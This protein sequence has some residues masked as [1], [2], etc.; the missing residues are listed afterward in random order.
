MGSS[1]LSYSKVAHNHAIVI[2]VNDIAKYHPVDYLIL[3]DP[4]SRFTKERM[5]VICNTDARI[6]TIYY[7]WEKYLDFIYKV[8]VAPI[9]SDISMLDSDYYVYSSNSPYVAAVHA[10]KLGASEIVMYGVDFTNH[11][12]L[13]GDEKIK[14]IKGDFYALYQA[15]LERGV[16]LYIGS[17]DT[18]LNGIIPLYP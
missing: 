5:D 4:P 8:E 3:I 17:P 13:S 16:K 10:Y 9:R 15:L 2:G 18:V 14:R 7:D 11:K 1:L 12:H 6:I